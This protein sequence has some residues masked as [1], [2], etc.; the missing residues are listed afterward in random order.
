MLPADAPAELDLPAFDARA[1]A[2]RAALP[3]AL[4]VAAAG[5]LIFAGGPMHA[6]SRALHRAI[7]ADPRWVLAAVAFEVISFSGYIALL[8]MVGE[9]ATPRMDL[10]ASAEVTLAGAAVTRLLPTGGAGGVALTLWAFRRTG[11]ESKH[12]T[13]TLLTFLVLL[14]A[15]FLLSIAG[16]GALLA[17]GLGGEGGH[18]FFAAIAG[19]GATVA[20]TLALAAARIDPREDAGRLGRAAATLGEGVRGAQAF[21]READIRL[22]G[23][24]LWWAFDAAVLYGMLNAF[25]TPP[26]PAVVILGYFVG[27]VANTIPIPGAVS[28]G[29]VGVLLAFGVEPDL[30]LA[31]VLAYRA[32]AIWLP[33]PVGLAALGSLRRTVARWGQEEPPRPVERAPRAWVPEPA[34]N[35]A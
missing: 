17:L 11:M 2:R 5:V 16:A 13:R 21:V 19:V 32:L 28:G 1:L 9:R 35:P 8:W 20:M 26:A 10:R 33:A 22:V 4:L 6:F 29:M 24:P 7:E 31:S 30:A 18:V 3:V 27:M 12:A 34:L 15:V 25:G 23:A 14:Y